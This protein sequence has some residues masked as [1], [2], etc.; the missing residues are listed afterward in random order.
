MF[1]ATLIPLCVLASLTLFLTCFCS[2]HILILVICPHVHSLYASCAWGLP[3]SHALAKLSA[4]VFLIVPLHRLRANTRAWLRTQ[5]SPKIP[6]SPLFTWCYD[7]FLCDATAISYSYCWY[8]VPWRITICFSKTVADV[9]ERKKIVTRVQTWTKDYP[10]YSG[11]S[12]R[13]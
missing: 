5:W 7:G 4:P 6:S 10:G 3:R 12:G 13:K 11:H 2:S 8:I 9:W 1:I